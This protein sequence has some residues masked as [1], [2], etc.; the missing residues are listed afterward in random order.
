[1]P[2]APQ[3]F[4]IRTFPLG[5][6]LGENKMAIAPYGYHGQTQ[7]LIGSKK[8][9]AFNLLG[10]LLWEF[11][12]KGNVKEI[13]NFANCD[14]SDQLVIFAGRVSE[15][16]LS[17]GEIL[18]FTKFSSHAYYFAG[19]QK[20]RNEICFEEELT[21]LGISKSLNDEIDFVCIASCNPTNRSK[22]I[23]Q[24]Y[25]TAGS[26]LWKCSLSSCI[27][28]L[29][30][31]YQDDRQVT[32]LTGSKQGTLASF[33]S[34]GRINWEQQVSNDEIV[35]IKT[36]HSSSAS[37]RIAV[38]GKAG[39]IS[40]VAVNGKTL[41]RQNEKSVLLDLACMDVNEDGEDEILAVFTNHICC[42]KQSG[43]IFW[44]IEFNERIWSFD[45]CPS[46]DQEIIV[47]A[48][49][50]VQI[51][52]VSDGSLNWNTTLNGRGVAC[53]TWSSNGQTWWAVCIQADQSNWKILDWF[54][55]EQ[56]YLGVIGR[57]SIHVQDLQH[58]G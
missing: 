7:I 44:R 20:P 9:Y 15:T 23:L 14:L 11:E 24:L 56:L 53:C 1:M 51:I 3:P 39:D 13:C 36:T 41:W 30:F 8:L 38:G 40:L 34:S 35:S 22:G 31:L 55:S 29:N 49:D 52:N 57:K 50:Q 47:C 33:N 28:K 46:L 4:V 26:R 19:G 45:H 12:T 32:W 5:L 17:G 21:A 16:L 2:D 54:G 48:G 18:L 42:Y 37:T 6:H 58:V 25:S 43:E 10:E 27:T